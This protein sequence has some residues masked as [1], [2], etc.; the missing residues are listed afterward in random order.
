MNAIFY[1]NNSFDNVLNKNLTQVFNLDL[2]LRFDFNLHSTE[3]KIVYT[4]NIDDVNYCY[5]SE[6]DRYYFIESIEK[7]AANLYTLKSN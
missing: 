6:V 4:G 5:I 2:N 3:I 7:V 1:T